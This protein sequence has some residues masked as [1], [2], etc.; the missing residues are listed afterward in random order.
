MSAAGA[1]PASAT[2]SA[3]APTIA[4]P[5]RRIVYDARL[6]DQHLPLHLHMQRVAEPLAVV[7]VD[8]GISRP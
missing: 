1:G 4:D 8:A 2:M 5:R 3:K 6:F 7:V